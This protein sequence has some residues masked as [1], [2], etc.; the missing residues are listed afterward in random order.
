MPEGLGLGQK[1]HIWENRDKKNQH[2]KESAPL[3]RKDPIF[4]Y[5]STPNVPSR[6]IQHSLGARGM[7]KN[8]IKK[9]PSSQTTEG[10]S[11]LY[12][13]TLGGK[14]LGRQGHRGKEKAGGVARNKRGG[15]SYL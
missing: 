11:Y 4:T 14:R 6:R 9:A 5:P 3:S 10:G 2:P 8:Q 1:R 7:Q 15:Q 13:G 12:L